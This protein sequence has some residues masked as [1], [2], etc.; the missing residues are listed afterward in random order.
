MR[1]GFHHINDDKH[2]SMVK[3]SV[4]VSHLCIVA[5]WLCYLCYL[6]FKNNWPHHFNF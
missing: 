1:W 3:F 2:K 4:R 5:C 6:L